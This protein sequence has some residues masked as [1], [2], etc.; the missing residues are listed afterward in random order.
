MIRRLA[1][2]GMVALLVA[3]APL[4]QTPEDTRQAAEQGYA[5]A[6]YNLGAMY[7]LGRGVPQDDVEAY[8]WFNLATTYADASIQET[9]AKQRDSVAERLTP[10]QRAEGQRLSREWFAAHPQQEP[11]PAE[12][13][14]VRA[15]AELGDAVCQISDDETYGFLGSNPVMVGGEAFGGPAR[16]RAYLDNLR[17][18]G[19]EPIS[20]ERVGSIPADGTF[21]DLYSLTY[22]GGEPLGIHIDQY[23]FENLRA[24]LGLICADA[25][26]GSTDSV[27]DTVTDARPQEPTGGIGT[28]VTI[29][30]REGDTIEGAFV[31]ANGTEVVVR[32][33]G[34]RLTLAMDVLR[35]I[36]FDGRIEASPDAGGDR[37]LRAAI[38]AL[39]ILKG[40]VEELEKEEQESFVISLN[41]ALP[42]VTSFLSSA[43]DNWLDVTHAIRMALQHYRQA[44]DRGSGELSGPDLF[45]ARGYVDYADKLSADSSE[46]GHREDAGETRVL[47]LNQIV[48][49]RLGAGDREMARELDGSSAGAYNDLFQ[50]TLTEPMRAEIVLL[51]DPCRPHLT[52]TGTNGEKIEGDAARYGRRSRIRRDLE[53]G[54]YYIWAGATSRGDVGEYTVEVGPRE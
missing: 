36:S 52:L 15:R 43:G 5:R 34:Q 20:Y 23:S 10:E 53:A 11:T 25:F 9:S 40:Q 13:A 14:D 22:P 51:C 33:A 45:R 37:K 24:P 8:N 54:T 6:Q 7:D 41:A 42:A 47:V 39:R 21:L 4:A 44:P 28:A 16:A 38:V 1:L 26:V 27:P 12:V 50:F 46:K 3:A 32:V 49:A 31:S 35:Y 19:G 2:A 30:T 29:E 18:P 48:E 17:G